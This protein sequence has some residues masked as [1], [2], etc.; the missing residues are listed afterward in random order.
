MDIRKP[1]Q[2]VRV[3]AKY[4]A[5]AHTL[6]VKRVDPKKKKKRNRKFIA[7]LIL[8][9]TILIIVVLTLRNKIF[10]INDI[11]ISGAREEYV[12]EIH[13]DSLDII[14]GNYFWLLP[15]R[16]I[17]IYPEEKIINNIAE[18][19][20]NLENISITRHGLHQVSISLNERTPKFYVTEQGVPNGI[21]LDQ[22]GYIFRDDLS[23]L[24]NRL[25][26][27]TPISE[28]DKSYTST[29]T[30]VLPI[31]FN[32]SVTK[33]FND[34]EYK[35]INELQS[36]FE[37]KGVPVYSIIILNYKDIELVITEQ[38]G[39]IRINL[40]DESEKI[41]VNF[42]AIVKTEPFKTDFLVKK[43]GLEYVDMRFGNKAFYRFK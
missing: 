3:E 7:Y 34:S 31:D 21:F 35:K 2:K 15:K 4:K 8:L 27:S 25:S 19:Y 33:Y 14:S 24:Q 38:G 18:K 5:G 29:S 39:V 23:R 1:T 10:F 30:G 40:D 41:L 36:G 11:T 20:S 13:R 12:A 6:K 28:S 37:K 42:S 26:S 32:K 43:S 9:I 17:L 22:N 16:N